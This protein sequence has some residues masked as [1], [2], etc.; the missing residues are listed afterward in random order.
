MGKMVCVKHNLLHRGVWNGEVKTL[1]STKIIIT[2]SSASESQPTVF[3]G[4]RMRS[5]VEVSESVSSAQT[6]AS[7]QRRGTM[8]GA[9]CRELNQHSEETDMSAGF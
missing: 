5:S 8:R 7:S 3:T 2:C 4:A 6:A 9:L 1:A